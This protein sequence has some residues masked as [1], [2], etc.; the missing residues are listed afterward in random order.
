[1]FKFADRSLDVSRND[2]SNISERNPQNSGFGT[3]QETA[4]SHAKSLDRSLSKSRR[5]STISNRSNTRSV[6]SN[7]RRYNTMNILNKTAAPQ[8]SFPK[9]S[10][11][12]VPSKEK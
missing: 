5:K 11:G 1:M 9:E 7:T 6:S 10:R 4:K 8:F 12:L 3:I 2:N